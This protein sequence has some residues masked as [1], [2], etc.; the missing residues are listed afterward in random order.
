[1]LQGFLPALSTKASRGSSR[2]MTAPISQ[3]GGNSVGTS[4]CCQYRCCVAH[5]EKQNQTLERVHQ[6]IQLPLYHEG[7]EFL[8]PQILDRH[9]LERGGLVDA[10]RR[11]ISRL[12]RIRV[13]GTCRCKCLHYH[14]RLNE[15]QL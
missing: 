1:M 13:V 11:R 5:V 9:V 8:C 3:P 14:I 7:L 15:C 2:S 4:A 10:S 12:D 6:K